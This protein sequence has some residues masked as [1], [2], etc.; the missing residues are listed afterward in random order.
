MNP[1]RKQFY[2]KKIGTMDRE[3]ELNSKYIMVEMNED[4]R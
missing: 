3:Y 4:G 1:S 2:C